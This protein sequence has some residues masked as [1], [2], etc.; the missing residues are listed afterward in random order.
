MRPAHRDGLSLRDVIA[1]SKLKINARRPSDHLHEIV[2]IQWPHG[3]PL[4]MRIVLSDMRDSGPGAHIL[5]VDFASIAFRAGLHPGD[6]IVGIMCSGVT[7]HIADGNELT[8]VAPSL[9]GDLNLHVR[10]Q[11]LTRQDVAAS[12][13]AASWRMAI[14]RAELRYE[15]EDASATGHAAGYAPG[16]PIRSP[17]RLSFGLVDDDEEW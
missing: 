10:R 9:F 12:A 17:P 13:I 11:Q 15:L 6:A 2:Q 14:T 4:G 16:S 1:A 3:S 8:L 5:T 7:H